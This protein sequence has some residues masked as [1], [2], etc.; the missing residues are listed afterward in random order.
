MRRANTVGGRQ[1]CRFMCIL[2]VGRARM[3]R[4]SWCNGAWLRRLLW[5]LA[6]RLILYLYLTRLTLGMW[7]WRRLL[8]GLL[9]A[10]VRELMVRSWDLMSLRRRGI[11]IMRISDLR[12]IV[13]LCAV[14][15]GLSAWSSSV[16]L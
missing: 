3:C 14:M 7:L 6:V 9:S 12:W 15:L 2:L 10:R 16:D 5:I 13:G 11:R 4:L 8:D 1:A